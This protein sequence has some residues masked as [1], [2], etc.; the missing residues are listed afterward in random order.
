MSEPV[1]TLEPLD[2]DGNHYVAHYRPR[3][4]RYL[5]SDGTLVDVESPR[6]DSD[7]RNAVVV[8]MGELR[9]TDISIVGVVQMEPE[10]HPPGRPVRSKGR[11]T[12][13]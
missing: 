13:K 4:F 8:T 9:R 3:M 6:D 2:D 12:E 5:L 11:R 10:P 1:V 7:L